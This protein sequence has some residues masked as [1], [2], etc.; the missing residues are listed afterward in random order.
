MP[1]ASSA[2]APRCLVA[3][4]AAGEGI[5]LAVLLADDQLRH[6][7]EPR[8]PGAARRPHPS[9]RPGEG[10]PGHQLRGPEHPRRP[11]AQEAA[12]PAQGNPRG[13]GNRPGLRRG[14]R[15]VSLEPSGATAPPDVRPADRRTPDPGPDRPR[16]QP[17]AVPGDH[18]IDPGRAGQTGAEPLG[19]CRPLG[20][21]QGAPARARGHR[22]V[23]RRIGP[24]DRA[25]S[26]ARSG[27][28]SHCYRVGKLPRQLV[29]IGNAAGEP[30]RPDRARLRHHR[31][32]QTA[33]QRRS[34]A[35][36]GHGPAIRSSRRYEPIC[37][38]IARRDHLQQG[39]VFYDLHRSEYAC[40]TCSA[41]RSRTAG[42]T[43]FI[44]G[45]SSSRRRVRGTGCSSASR[46]CFHD[47]A[48]APVGTPA[49]QE[50]G[51][52]PICRNGPEGAAHKL[53]QSPFPV[54]PRQTVEQFL[55]QQKLQPWIEKASVERLAEVKR[56]ARA[57]WRSASTP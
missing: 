12:R 20:R 6:S 29:E 18:R 50:K 8:P 10:L 38:F 44:A 11:R 3:T 7:L 56:V 41:P 22:A 35:R 30:V 13:P 48:P 2:K 9:L 45:C 53:D 21:G 43:R 15:G 28:E 34:D 23:L 36:M 49:P 40:S 37:S 54:P 1:S 26:Q 52:G 46:R 31:L 16:L 47:I 17:R 14:G 57:T 32:R 24:R 33:P 51:T 55:Y 19:D 27:K 4:E 5:N 42:A 39:A 25:A